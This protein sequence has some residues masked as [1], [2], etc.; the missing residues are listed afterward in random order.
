MRL[1]GLAVLGLALAMPTWVSAAEKISGRAQVIDARTLA[2]DGAK[3]RVRLFGVDAPDRK[4]TCSNWANLKYRCG[5]NATHALAAIVGRN[6]QVTCEEQSRDKDGRVYAICKKGDD[7]IG[8]ELIRRGWA[9]DYVK[10]SHGRYAPQ[11]AEAK[12]ARRGAWAGKWKAPWKWRDEQ[13]PAVQ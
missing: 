12:Q 11:E 13:H 4:Q 1:V 2:V 10:Y 6:G 8:A 3:E 5:V 9:R 7:D